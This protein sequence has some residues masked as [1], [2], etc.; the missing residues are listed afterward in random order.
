MVIKGLLFL[1]LMLFFT[2]HVTLM[3]ILSYS[4]LFSDGTILCLEKSPIPS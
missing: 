2:L 4:M 3:C 1:L